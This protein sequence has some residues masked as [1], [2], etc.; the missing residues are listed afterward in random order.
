MQ[1]RCCCDAGEWES[2]DAFI[3]HLHSE[4]FKEFAEVRYKAFAVQIGMRL[5]NA[6][7]GKQV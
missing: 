7:E 3:D 5:I 2:V 6:Y 1:S 4:H